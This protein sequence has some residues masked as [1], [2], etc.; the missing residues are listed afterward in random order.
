MNLA[1]RRGGGKHGGDLP[2]PTPA[3]A[4]PQAGG[5]AFPTA[6]AFPTLDALPMADALPTTDLFP[7]AAVF[8][9]SPGGMLRAQRDAGVDTPK[10]GV[11]R[12]A[13]LTRKAS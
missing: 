10:P 6:D 4:A 13:W 2:L 9:L 11:Q 3:K 1:K 12:D 5:D 7:T 8:P